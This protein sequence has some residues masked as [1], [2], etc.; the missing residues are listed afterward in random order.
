MTISDPDQPAS[1]PEVKRA[2]LTEGMLPAIHISYQITIAANLMAFGSSARNFKEFGLNVG[3]WRI[4]GLLGQM[5]PVTA[6]KMAELLTQDKAGIS[7]SIAALDARQLIVKIPNPNHKRSP[8]IWMSVAGMDL[9]ERIV[10]VFTEQ[11][12]KFCAGLSK[13]EQIMFCKLLDKLAHHTA[14]VRRNEGL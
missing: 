6:S 11:A 7:R 9:Y 12:E 8:H 1:L 4:I 13:D 3:E 2:Y 10:P 14:E 5:G